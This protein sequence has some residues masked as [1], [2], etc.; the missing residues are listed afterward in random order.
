[1]GW[2]N[3]KI[4]KN[5]NYFQEQKINSFFILFI[6]LWLQTQKPVSPLHTME[7][8]L[9]HRQ[10]LKTFL[11]LNFIRKKVERQVSNFQ[12]ILSIGKFKCCQFQQLIFKVENVF[13]CKKETCP[14]LKVYF[15]KPVDAAAHWN[16]RRNKK[17]AFS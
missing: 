3:V 17:T 10:P 8:S 2:N 7:K 15:E 5:T 9:F 4:E 11:L 1:M 16:K 6:L 14:Q 13:V 12:K